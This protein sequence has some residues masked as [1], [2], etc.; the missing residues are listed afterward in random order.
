MARRQITENILNALERVQRT[1]DDPATGIGALYKDQAELRRKVLETVSF[2]TT[3]LREE[4]RELRR[5]QEKMI[6]DLADT[7]T[8]VE[9]L[10]RELAQAWAHTMGIPNPAAAAS[11]ATS[12]EYEPRQLE[13]GQSNRRKDEAVH[14]STGQAEHGD[15]SEEPQAQIPENTAPDAQP[16][17][18]TEH[19]TPHTLYTPDG[20]A[21]AAG[22]QVEQVEQVE[23]PAGGSVLP[24]RDLQSDSRVFAGGLE[25]AASI[26]SA[27]LVCHRDTWEFVFEQAS[28]HKHFRIPG[29][30][31]DLGEGQ[32]ETFLSGR[33]L[34]A[35]LA[36][37]RETYRDRDVDVATWA[38][39]FAVYRRTLDAVE[40]AGRDVPSGSEITT[41]V[42][43]DR[44]DPGMA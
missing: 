33:S 7:R 28:K 35:V 10:R 37:M 25:A 20:A 31:S 5:R 43:D 36:S 8:A 42:L 1:L 21:A 2:G 16:D 4:N 23:Q 11:T 38:L 44:T 30:I 29:R 12:V 17:E 18:R 39:A 34:L 6:G 27:R 19:A 24:E 40:R 3:G 41:I 22:E 14:E 32:V 15:K 9:T 13:A 26:G